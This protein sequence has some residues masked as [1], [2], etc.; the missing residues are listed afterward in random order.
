[1]PRCGH[2]P[3]RGNKSGSTKFVTW[4]PGTIFVPSLESCVHR[5]KGIRNP[6]RECSE[7]KRAFRERRTFSECDSQKLCEQSR[8]LLVVVVRDRTRVGRTPGYGGWSHERLSCDSLLSTSDLVV[9][10]LLA[11]YA[12][13]CLRRTP[14]AESTPRST[15]RALLRLWHPVP[16][17]QNV[18]R[19][20]LRFF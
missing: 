12:H 13:R 4:R 20:E 6:V 11:P 9:R 2:C 15:R 5:A 7:R 19:P 8:D 3:N 14:V 10:R 17:T 1:M 18:T 16:T